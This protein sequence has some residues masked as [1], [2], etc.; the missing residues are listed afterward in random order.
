MIALFDSGIGGLSVWRHVRA[1]LP[2]VPL[3]YFADQANVPY[4][5][6]TAAEILRYA[7]RISRYLIARGAKL[8]V[9]A[10]NTATAAAINDLRQVYPGVSFV[11]MEPAIKPAAAVTRSGKVGVLATAGT[12]GSQRYVE[13]AER[14]GQGLVLYENRCE[15]LVTQIEAGRMETP[16]T[17]ELLRSIVNPMLAEGV[18]TLILGCTHYPFIRPVLAEL[19]G[20]QV[21]II[22]PAPAVAEQTKRVWERLQ[23][24]GY[25]TL[26]PNRFVTTGPLAPFVKQLS[27][28]S[29]LIDSQPPNLFY[30][31]SYKN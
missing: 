6:R 2:G 21:E 3:L 20:P 23:V 22:D 24:D 10:C 4:G 30:Q 17:V 27:D 31:K 8:I 18:D 14:F 25:A 1:L 12:F 29:L 15:G 5:G 13:L 11:G 7:D 28:V 19:V 26:L 9:I 16:D